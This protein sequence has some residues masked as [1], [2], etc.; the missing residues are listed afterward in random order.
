VSFRIKGDYYR[1]IMN[2]VFVSMDR[3]YVSYEVGIELLDIN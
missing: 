2:G 3:L 1:S